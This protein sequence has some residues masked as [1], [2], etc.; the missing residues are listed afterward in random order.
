[1][2]ETPDK[3]SGDFVF[4]LASERV[5]TGFYV[6]VIGNIGSTKTQIAWGLHRRAPLPRALFLEPVDT[7]LWGEYLADYYP[8]AL[9][10]IDRGRG[11]L[12][13]I[14]AFAERYPQSVVAHWLRMLGVTCT[15][16]GGPYID[17]AFKSVATAAG[18]IHPRHAALY[19]RLAD[20]MLSNVLGPN[21][22]I[23]SALPP[24]VCHD[25]LK[26]R[27]RTVEAGVPL[28]YLEALDPFIWQTAS[29]LA[30]RGVP[31][32]QINDF[33]GPEDLATPEADA[34][35]D[36]LWLRVRAAAKEPKGHPINVMATAIGRPAFITSK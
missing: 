13:Q 36:E 32:V 22:V 19:D 11:A 10:G 20:V 14:Y 4:G 17:P 29:A 3:N 1:M 26:R 33:W 18:A 8:D 21:V 28:S 27:G 25:N 16:D 34:A 7:P 5:D 9:S 30:A 24:R 23:H 12:M 15:H 31:V 2:I 35:F 6:S